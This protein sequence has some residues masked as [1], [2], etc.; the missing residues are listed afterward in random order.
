MQR[1]LSAL[2]ER[3]LGNKIVLLTGPRQSGKTWIS[4]HFERSTEYLSYDNPDQREIIRSRSWNRRSELIVLDELHKMPLWTGFLKGVYDTEGAS[5]P[6]LVAGSARPGIHR[7]TGESL[8]GRFFHYRLHPFDV[9]ELAGSMEPRVVLE[10][11]CT[12]GGFPEPFLADDP[13]FHRRWRRTHLDVILR[14]DLLDTAQV[15]G[16]GGARLE[17]AVACSLVK[18]LQHAED[19]DGI[20]R[21]LHY[22]R[23][24]DGHELDFCVVQDNSVTHVFEVKTS[25]TSL[26]PAFSWFRT[27]FPD[28]RRIQLVAET[29]RIQTWPSGEELHRRVYGDPSQRVVCEDTLEFCNDVVPQ[30]VCAKAGGSPY[31]APHARKGPALEVAVQLVERVFSVFAKQMVYNQVSGGIK[32]P[33]GGE[34][35]LC[36]YGGA[37]KRQPRQ[38]N[39][40]RRWSGR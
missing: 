37:F 23:T 12:T 9:R 3:D 14:Q 33:T 13:M 17:N 6:L 4:R 39:Q 8:A 27:R 11:I 29:D 2:I 10:K 36:V 31:G 21:S 34:R 24:R 25:D 32:P 30:V 1:E 40:T 20:P 19:T 15:S 18:A 35:C 38:K 16:Q 22:L 5:P 26:S 28:A 7:R